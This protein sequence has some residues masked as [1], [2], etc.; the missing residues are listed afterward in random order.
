MVGRSIERRKGMRNVLRKGLGLA[1]VLALSHVSWAKPVVEAGPNGGRLM[2]AG[3]YKVEFHV[4][5][6]RRAHVRLYGAKLEPVPVQQA[7]IGL[8]VLKGGTKTLEL[9][10]APLDKKAGSVA[11]LVTRSALPSPDG[12]LLS[13]SV[14]A[15]GQP[16]NVLR[17]NYLEE[18]CKGCSRPEYACTCGH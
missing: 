13:L 18:I 12:Y 2:A 1:V 4:G 9:V 14:K 17:F 6:D 5:K 7:V 11:H 10:K 8:K 15:P 3:K 16:A